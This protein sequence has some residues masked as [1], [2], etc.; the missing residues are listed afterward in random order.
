MC[1]SDPKGVHGEVRREDAARSGDFIA[2]KRLGSICL[3]QP[4]RSPAASNWQ[5][6]VSNCIN[7]PPDP[8]R[9][10]LRDAKRCKFTSDSDLFLPLQPFHHCFTTASRRWFFG[11]FTIVKSQILRR[12]LFPTALTTACQLL[13]GLYYRSPLLHATAFVAVSP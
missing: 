2:G 7:S 10:I 6:S 8:V 9:Q 12:M 5:A 1:R 11:S 4:G 13:A 3:M